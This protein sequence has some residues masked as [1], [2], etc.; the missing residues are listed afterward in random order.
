LTFSA[1]YV[2]S[3]ELA[4]AGF[5]EAFPIRPRADAVRRLF[6]KPEI[7]DLLNGKASPPGGFPTTEADEVIGRF[8]AGWFVRVSE[9]SKKA[10]FERLERLDEVWALCA[11]KPGPGWRI[12]GR[13]LAPQV[14]VGL[15]AFDR[16]VLGRAENYE[17]LAKGMI[18]EW[19]KS[20]GTRQPFRGAFPNDYLGEHAWNLDE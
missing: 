8:C 11:R 14:F 6:L 15:A 4:S 9:K 3:S 18:D 17:A 20:L 7:I 13:F 2:D 16:R 1:T 10:D 12:L 19:G 5:V